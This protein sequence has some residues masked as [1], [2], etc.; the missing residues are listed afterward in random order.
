M[1]FGVRSRGQNKENQE[2]FCEAEMKYAD[3]FTLTLLLTMNIFF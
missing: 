3:T 1:L 2:Q